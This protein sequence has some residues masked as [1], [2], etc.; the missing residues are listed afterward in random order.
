MPIAIAPFQKAD[1]CLKMTQAGIAA[2]WGCQRHPDFTAM[3]LGNMPVPALDRPHIPIKCGWVRI[4]SVNGPDEARRGD[5]CQRNAANIIWRPVGRHVN[6]L[7][8]LKKKQG[9]AAHDD[10]PLD[11]PD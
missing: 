8:K 2:V 1:F 3:N 11:C 10:R 5:I 9:P 4:G 7:R 6:S